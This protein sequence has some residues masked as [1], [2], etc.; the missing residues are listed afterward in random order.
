[1]QIL[2]HQQQR[3]LLAFAQQHALQPVEG[4]LATL[5]WI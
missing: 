3:L 2:E 5:G 4:A 1:V